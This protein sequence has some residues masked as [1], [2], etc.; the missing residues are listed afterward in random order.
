MSVPVEKQTIV[1]GVLAR[2]CKV[3]L[4]R[5]MNRVEEV[6]QAFKDY[7]VVIYENDSKDGTTEILKEWAARNP[8]VVAI[9]ETTNKITIPQ[10][11]KKSPYPLKSVHRIE[12]MGRFRNRVLD[13]VRSRFNPDLFCFIDIDVESFSPQDV[14]DAIRQVPSD[15]GA[16]FASGQFLFRKPDGTDKVPHFQYDSYAFVPDGVDPMKTGRWVIS[17]NYHDVTSWLFDRLLNHNEYLLCRSAFNG[18]GI[19]RWEAIRDLKFSIMQTPELKEV[20]ACFCEHIPFNGEIIKKGYRLYATKK[21]EV[22]YYHKRMTLVRRF[23]HW[24][25]TIKVRCIL[26]GNFLGTNL[27]ISLRKCKK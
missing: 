16:L 17:H 23:N 25:R 19:Y 20:S 12:R 18:I 27:N 9:C 6:G 1:F 7:D 10:K 8:H 24:I 2:D 21:I 14:V 4:L 22:I 26:A 5:N 13:E 15:W 11:T 3:S